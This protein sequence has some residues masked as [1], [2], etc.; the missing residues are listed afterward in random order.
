MGEPR[1]VAGQ[2]ERI[3]DRVVD[4]TEL[5]RH[6]H[7][8]CEAAA[9]SSS[10]ESECLQPRVEIMG[11]SLCILGSTLG[12]AALLVAAELHETDWR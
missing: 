1:N 4:E 12:C 3:F 2:E 8:A 6:G 7:G 9:L 5:A 10:Q 11:L